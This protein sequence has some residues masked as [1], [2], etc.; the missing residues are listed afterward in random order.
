MVHYNFR[1]NKT[2]IDFR[3]IAGCKIEIQS[4]LQ[5]IELSFAIISLAP[6]GNNGGTRDVY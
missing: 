1:R 4:T 5:R 2:P 6:L 3:T